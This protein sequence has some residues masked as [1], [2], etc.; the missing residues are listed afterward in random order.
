VIAPCRHAEG[1]EERLGPPPHVD[2]RPRHVPRGE[3]HVVER[4]ERRQQLEGLE[5]EAD[6]RAAHAAL[7]VARE[8]TDPL[9]AEPDLT[10]IGVLEETEHVEERRL[11]RP[12][13][14]RDDGEL[15]GFHVQIDPAQDR[16]GSA[17][18]TGIGLDEPAG[19][20][21]QLPRRIASAGDRRATRAV[22]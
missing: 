1:L 13:R 8:R 17:I 14:P 21:H 12:R 4:G 11:A 2:V 6:A 19:A 18:G 5:D 7:A 22:A 15:A 20:Q 3:E 10:A 16:D 9:V